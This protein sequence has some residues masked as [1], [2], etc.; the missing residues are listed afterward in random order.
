MKYILK[1]ESETA[2]T[3]TYSGSGYIEPWTS[4]TKTGSGSRVD[5]NKTEEQKREEYMRSPL[6]MDIIS[7]GYVVWKAE[8]ASSAKTIEVRVNDGSWS[9]ITSSSVGEYIWAR[10]GDRVQFRGDNAQYNTGVSKMNH[11]GNSSC[12]FKLSGNIMSL[13]NSTGFTGITAISG[14]YAFCS[15]FYGCTGLT[16]AGWLML[17]ARSLSEGAYYTMFSGCINMTKAPELTGPNRGYDGMF[18]GCSGLT[19]APELPATNVGAWGYEQMFRGCT[20]ITKAPVLP[21]NTLGNYAYNLMFYNASSINYVKCLAMTPTSNQ[22]SGWLDGV[23]ASGTF[24]KA[25]G[26]TWPGGSIPSGWTVETAS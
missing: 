25:D 18:N 15:L 2:F 9:G 14:N 20:S 4:M 5:Y 13:I 21:A 23:A 16:D 17:P 8:N 3:Q 6:T 22:V 7:D 12:R 10:A 11:F 26:S 1:F 19:E 24:V